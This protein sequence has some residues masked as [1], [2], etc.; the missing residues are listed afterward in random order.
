MLKILV[1][2]FFPAFTPPQS[3]GELRYFNMYKN[4]SKYF[5]ITLLSPTYNEHEFELIEHSNTFREYRIPKENIHNEIHW[6]LEQEEF[7]SEFSALTN[8][9]VGEHFNNYHKQYLKIYDE[10]DIIIHDFPYMI[11]YDLFF[12]IDKKPRIY[13]SH[14][15]E[16]DLMSQIYKG[17]NAKKHLDYVFK[18]EKQLID[19]SDIIFVTSPLE[20]NKLN[21]LYGRNILDIKLAPNGITPEDYLKRDDKIKRKTAFFIGSG[22]PPN[23]EAVDFIIN[24]LADKCPD[25]EF[26]IAGT[27][28]T[29]SECKKNNVKLLGKVNK[30]EKDT[31]F[32]SSDVSINPMFAGAGT[33]LKTLEYLSMGIPM[34]S[35][36]VGVRGIDIIDNEHFILAT[37]ESFSERLNDLI[38]NDD[39]KNTLS[40]KSKKYINKNFDWKNIA[41]NVA[42][43]I[44]KLKLSKKKTILL[45]NDF[46]V[47]SPFGGGEIR[48]NHLYTCLSKYYNILL[49]CLN[50]HNK[51]EKIQIS[52]NFIELSIPKT[53]EHKNEENNI[54][55]KHWVSANDIVSSYMIKKNENFMN[56][57]DSI[58]SSFDFTVLTHIYMYEAIENKKYKTLVHES[59]NVELSLK[60]VML[61]KHPLSSKLIEQVERIERLSVC[62]SDI[63]IS[64]SNDDH[65]GLKQ[66]NDKKSIFTVQ[67]GV[68]VLSNHSISKEFNYI[69][70]E[71]SNKTVILFIGSAHMPNIDSARF[72]INDLSLRHSDCY[73]AIVGSVGECL[74][75]IEL[76]FNVKI[77]GKVKDEEKKAIC[78]YSD[79]ALNPMYNGSGSNLKIIDYFSSKIPTITTPF[80]ARGFLI[81]NGQ[82]AIICDIEKFSDNIKVLQKNKKLKE[83]L[84]DNSYEYVKQNLDWKILA[85]KYMNILEKN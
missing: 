55:S 31:L 54:N 69:K 15:L 44:K 46:Q 11:N 1:M 10:I 27:C 48:I 34:V 45:L 2:N 42:N 68:R 39:L 77:Y 61:K 41:K 49:L 18:L 22:H 79:I 75:D 73:F 82:N 35:T 25:I 81:E 64:V 23:L 66:Y 3:G 57:L 19:G 32:R 14:N 76:P 51:F 60:K 9:Y 12:G 21:K 62:N 50:N 40:M 36:N 67:N 63:V 71:L 16:Y 56:C 6:K 83:F 43:E 85:E 26:L 78:M 28:C 58:V 5:D 30:I 7:A 59:L 70:D 20:I 53:I 24:D 17:K 52:E 4:L 47:S 38:L 33:N 84:V 74:Q 13:N 80:G 72:I 8:A 29:R 37:K 65:D